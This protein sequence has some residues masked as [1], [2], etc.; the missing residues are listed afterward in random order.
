[1][2]KKTIFILITIITIMMTGCINKKDEK[3]EDVK[4]KV[5]KSR[6]ETTVTSNIEALGIKLSVEGDNVEV[7][8]NLLYIKTIENGNTKIYIT[9]KNEI[10]KGE[11][12]VKIIGLSSIEIKVEEIIR[13]DDMVV[14][15]DLKKGGTDKLLGDFN[16]D[17]S[18]NLLDFNEFAN[19]FLLTYN[20]K[21]DIAPAQ[22]GTGEWENIYSIANSDDL[23]DLLD[24]VIFGKNYDKSILTTG[25]FS[26]IEP[27]SV[28]PTLSEFEIKI[29]G[30]N[31]TQNAS[32][33]E[34]NLEYDASY[35]EI[36]KVNLL[37]ALA[38][39]L[40]INL[41]PSVNSIEISA[42]NPEND[43]SLNGEL[44][45][46]VCKSKSN[47]GNAQV[48]LKSVKI[49]NPDLSENTSATISDKADL[50]FEERAPA[51]ATTINLN[52]NKS[53]INING[54]D[55]LTLTAVVKDQYGDVMTGETVNYYKGTT[56]L[57]GNTFT[58]T[59]AGTYKFK[60][61]SGT[62]ESNEVTVI[63]E[64]IEESGY[65]KTN[66]NGQV[67]IYNSSM[68]VE[69]VNTMSDSFA[70]WSE[71]ML[72]VQGVAN[73][74]AGSF[75]GGHEYPVYDTYSLYATWDDE[76]LYLGWQ[77]VYVND[78][79][80]PANNGGN[81]AKPTNADIPQMF[82][83]DLDPNKA[84]TGGLPSGGDV[85]G[86]GK[87]PYKTFDISLGVD[88][89]AMFSSKGGVG[90]P[91]LFFMNEETNLFS[92][93]ETDLKNFKDVD[94][95][96]GAVYGLLPS[97]VYGIKDNS[98]GSYA[99]ADLL[100]DTG[101]VDMLEEGHNP[102]FDCFYEMKIPF[103]ALGID[104]NYIE[105]T[106]I[107]VMHISTYGLSGVASIPFD[108][109]TLDNAEGDYSADPSSSAEKDD[110]DNFTSPLARIGK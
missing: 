36:M 24:L 61:K 94:I 96:Y 68:N 33:I 53:K 75:K 7:E 3:N 86:D 16:N 91:A 30:A 14:K 80:D 93:E 84:T 106:G 101:W 11:E 109:T 105:N 89:I 19:A 110:L 27:V 34:L 39:G 87:G 72:I 103:T 12:L 67:G 17:G 100:G 60:A 31:F 43:F 65:Y 81:E 92:Y 78:V 83:F 32:G 49:L 50:V 13:K 41:N 22:K 26:F 45:A 55:T 40:N 1:M 42:A 2:K 47:G 25:L 71:D 20:S 102:S 99:P 85:W 23:V 10:K 66:P 98:W 56:V 54:S 8:S 63:A 5:E 15:R 21:Y 76:N 90:Q 38:S 82:A 4:I 52:A 6:N 35:M 64:E 107:G 95:V 77:F 104:R 9:N 44:V 62:L 88:T 108:M 37:G 51:K 46:L 59:T 70:D 97:T 79:V 18:V 74:H 29:S 48:I 69:C 73:D 58:T 57:S 28:I